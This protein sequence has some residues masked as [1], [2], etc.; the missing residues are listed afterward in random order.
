[1]LGVRIISQLQTIARDFGV[2]RAL[3]SYYYLPMSKL[4]DSIREGGPWE[5]RRA[6]L[7]RLEMVTA[8]RTLRIL[9]VAEGKQQL[10]VHF[11]TGSKYWY[12]TLFCAWSLQVNS[13]VRI[14]PVIYDDGTLTSEH[15]GYI[16]RAIPWTKVVW[17][18]SIESKL[19][20]VLPIQRF[21]ELRSRRLSYPH[22][23][24]LT[25]IHCS[26][27]GWTLVLDSDM[28]F[29][30]EPRFILEW[31]SAS[32][33]PCHMVDAMH[34]YGYSTALMESLV[35]GPIPQLVNVGFCGFK[36]SSID[37]EKLEYW[38]STLIAREGKHYYLEQALSAMLLANQSRKAAPQSEYVVLPS[39]DEGQKPTAV[40]HHYVA[41]SKRSYFQYGWR[42]LLSNAYQ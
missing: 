5:Q 23:R 8:A 35:G 28:L 10:Q 24:K 1:M 32:D 36:S 37:W 40:L 41:H 22:L 14:T 39:L 18:S 7:G 29:Y 9:S 15:V 30:R 31:L 13:P 17:I 16:S 33:M 25:D 3:L 26:S 19:D 2:G 12:Q 38:C 6:E 20:Q 4:R 34:S 42:L 21:P 27:E 11:L